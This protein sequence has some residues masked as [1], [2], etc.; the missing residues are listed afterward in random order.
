MKR[1]DNLKSLTRE[2]HKEA[3]NQTF[4]KKILK[5][6][7]T[8]EEYAT[9]LFNQYYCYQTLENY[10]ISQEIFDTEVFQKIE[11][12]KLILQD[13]MELWNLNE[14]YPYFSQVTK[15]YI[16]HLMKIKN[17]PDKLLSHVYVRYMGDLSGGQYIASKVPG[18]GRMYEFENVSE[19]KK[20]IIEKLHDGLEQEAKIA[21]SYV[22]QLFIDLERKF[23]HA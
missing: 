15:D 4:V 19:C 18:S 20:K 17:N 23:T 21:F 9:Y 16:K 3:E 1:T 6:K 7:I 11:R 8:K 13:L 5:R 2:K 14:S 12:S 10:V 22:T